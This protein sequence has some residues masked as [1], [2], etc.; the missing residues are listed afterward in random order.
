MSEGRIALLPLSGGRAREGDQTTP[1]VVEQELQRMF[2]VCAELLAENTG[3]SREQVMNDMT[4]WLELDA[5][6]AKDYGL[7]D[8]VVDRPPHK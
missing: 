7:I 1:E 4:N 3:Q 5:T 8:E 2:V 6:D